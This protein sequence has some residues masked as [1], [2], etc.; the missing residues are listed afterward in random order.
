[1]K[2]INTDKLKRLKEGLHLNN[3]YLAELLDITEEE[4][5]FI[6]S[7]ECTVTNTQLDTLCKVYGVNEEYLYA[8]D[9]RSNLIHARIEGQLNEKDEKQIA[10]FFNFQR[11]SGKKRSKELIIR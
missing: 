11:S 8:S 4:Y 6:E 5:N 7:D 9:V 10:E 1:M 3:E 2:R